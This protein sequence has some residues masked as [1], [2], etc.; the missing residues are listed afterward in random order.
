MALPS[1]GHQKFLRRLAFLLLPPFLILIAVCL[2]ALQFQEIASKNEALSLTSFIVLLSF[3]ALAFNW[4]RVSPALVPEHTLKVLYTAG[5]DLFLA[6]LLALVATFF[7]KVQTVNLPLL[8]AMANPLFF[9]LHW[10]FLLLSLLLFLGAILTILRAA[11]EKS[12]GPE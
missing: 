9:V 4:C 11:R 5:V 6:S 1:S 10:I 12:D 8:P 2:L 3:S 7:A